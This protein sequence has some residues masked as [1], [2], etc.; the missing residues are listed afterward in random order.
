MNAPLWL[1]YPRLY[2]LTEEYRPTEAQM[3]WAYQVSNPNGRPL[4]NDFAVCKSTPRIDTARRIPLP[5]MGIEGKF[6]RVLK[7]IDPG[8]PTPPGIEI[9]DHEYFPGLRAPHVLVD[10]A[11]EGWSK[12]AFWHNDH[13]EPC[14]IQYKRTI[15]IPFVGRRVLKFYHGLKQDVTFGDWMGWLEP[16]MSLTKES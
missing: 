5:L 7:R 3:P 1:L 6:I 14:V 11:Q 8:Y 13:W 10:Y 16:A 15:N 2:R 9:V 4:H 12:F